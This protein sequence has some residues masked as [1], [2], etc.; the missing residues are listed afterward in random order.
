MLTIKWLSIPAALITLIRFT[1]TPDPQ[2]NVRVFPSPM[3]LCFAFLCISRR[4]PQCTWC[5]RLPS[6][7]HSIS[8]SKV[9]ELFLVRMVHYPVSND[10]DSPRRVF[11]SLQH[12]LLLIVGGILFWLFLSQRLLLVFWPWTFSHVAVDPAYQQ[13]RGRPSWSRYRRWFDFSPSAGYTIGHAITHWILVSVLR[14]T[15]RVLLKWEDITLSEEPLLFGGR[16][17]YFGVCEGQ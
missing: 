8:L 3:R 17:T 14:R 15:K 10:W 5:Y 6:W 13:Y 7:G 16:L 1:W 12:I 2:S 9:Q 11:F 4:R